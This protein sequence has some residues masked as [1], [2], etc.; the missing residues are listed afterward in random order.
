MKNRIGKILNFAILSMFFVAACT[1]PSD[2]DESN[3][4]LVNEETEIIE[5][6]EDRQLVN[7]TAS[8]P[9]PKPIEEEEEMQ[10]KKV[11]VVVSRD[12][13]QSLELIPVLTEL[14]CGGYEAVISSD[15][16][17]TAIGTT[18]NKEVTIAFKDINTAD[19]IGI[20]L[21]G[22]SNSL[23]YNGELHAVINAMNDEEKLV[24]AICY[25]SVTLATGKV[26]GEGDTACWYNSSESDPVMQ[27]HGVLDTAM[28]VTIN[29]NI[30]TGDGPNAAEEFAKA[31]VD[32]LN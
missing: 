20:V 11:L 17:G 14:T 24:A 2:A 12:R 4:N 28:D 22:G 15:E 19:Y 26:I 21:I 13:Y 8:T 16:I 5:E 9:T 18:E 10:N 27:E 29:D 23:W 1:S 30:I 7:E 31:V 6:T 32:Y 25:G 3:E